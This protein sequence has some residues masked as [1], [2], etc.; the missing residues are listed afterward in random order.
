VE[1]LGG[2]RPPSANKK[3]KKQKSYDQEPKWFSERKKTK[4]LTKNKEKEDESGKKQ[5]EN[6]GGELRR[7]FFK[8]GGQGRTER[9][10]HKAKRGKAVRKR[11]G[12]TGNVGNWD[13]KF[14]RAVVGIKGGG[15]KVKRTRRAQ[16]QESVGKRKNIRTVV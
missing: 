7:G 5:R 3:K 6:L 16:N 11:V 10:L 13:K 15:K 8:R 4:I 14:A 2:G 9:D 12:G 1:G